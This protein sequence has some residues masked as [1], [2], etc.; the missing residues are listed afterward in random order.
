MYYLPWGRGDSIDSTWELLAAVVANSATFSRI[1]P[2]RRD[3][4]LDAAPLFCARPHAVA[5]AGLPPAA[6]KGHGR[7]G[8]GG[9]VKGK[10]ALLGGLGGGRGTPA[11][12]PAGGELGC[13]PWTHVLDY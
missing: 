7:A 9:K 12:A 6:T 10:E 13:A 2:A 5:Q 1:L 4:G 3:T 8:R 11:P